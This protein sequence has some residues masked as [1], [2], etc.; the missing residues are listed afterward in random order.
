MYT[1]VEDTS[2]IARAA[3]PT[4]GRANGS[5][6]ATTQWKATGYRDLDEDLQPWGLLF[7]QCDSHQI[8][9]HRGDL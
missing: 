3:A 4:A 8:I 1:R 2:T 9:V 5:W 7:W 6:G